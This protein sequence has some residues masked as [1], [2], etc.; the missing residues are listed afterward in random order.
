MTTI[1]YFMTTWSLEF[2]MANWRILNIQKTPKTDTPN[3][4]IRPATQTATEKKK[5][6]NTDKYM[7]KYVQLYRYNYVKL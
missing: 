1:L 6:K 2:N 5:K 3:E 4:A 7:N